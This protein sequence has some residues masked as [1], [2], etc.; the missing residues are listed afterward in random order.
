MPS[1]RKRKSSEDEKV[2]APKKVANTR[3]KHEL[4]QKK[5]DWRK[6]KKTC[7]ADG[8]TNIVVKGGVCIKHGAK[9]K[10]CSSEG[11]SNYAVKGGVCI[12]HGAQVKPCNNEGCTNFAQRGGVCI[13]HGA[14]IKRCSSEGCSNKAKK[15]GVCI[16]HGATWTK[17]KCNK[18]GCSNKAQKGGVCRRHGATV[19][20]CSSEGVQI[21]LRK[22]EYAKGMGL[23]RNDLDVTLK[24][25]QI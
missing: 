20:R 17:K 7:K 23:K 3:E 22:E 19:K 24:D 10:Q 8:C 6:Y 16:R 9:V 13:K 1:K 14:N 15:G 4:P 18:E 21:K 12:K 25:A 2:Q 11:C 5:L